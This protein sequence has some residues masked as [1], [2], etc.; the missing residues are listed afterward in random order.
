LTLDQF[1]TLLDQSHDVDD[2]KKL[3]NEV[4]ET[5]TD[6]RPPEIIERERIRWT[7]LIRRDGAKIRAARKARK[8]KR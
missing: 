2:A 3:I 1:M 4:I 7:N 8:S 5:Y 6:H